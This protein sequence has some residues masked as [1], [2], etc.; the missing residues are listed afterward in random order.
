VPVT[1]KG[2]RT[3]VAR[4]GSDPPRVDVV[5]GVAGAVEATAVAAACELAVSAGT[6]L[7]VRCSV[8]EFQPTPE[9]AEARLAGLGIDAERAVVTVE[10]DPDLVDAHVAVAAV[11]LGR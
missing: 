6:A 4:V 1:K 5:S 7:A 2:R 8:V 10:R 3:A 11:T 9:A